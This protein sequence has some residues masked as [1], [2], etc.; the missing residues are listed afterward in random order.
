MT[1]E[2]TQN[3]RDGQFEIHLDGD[4]VGCGVPRR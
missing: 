3:S 4:R 2:V 1:T